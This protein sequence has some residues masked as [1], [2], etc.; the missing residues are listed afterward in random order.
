MLEQADKDKKKERVRSVATAKDFKYEESIR[1]AKYS[2]DAHLSG[3]QGD[4]TAATIDLYL[5]PSGDEL[6]RA[7]ASD[8]LT[9][10]EQNRKT[11]G[12]HMTYT[13]AD[14]RY[15]VTGAPVSIVDQC[16][17]ET[18]GKTLTFVKAT[19]TID[20][21]GNQRIRTQTK[22]GGKCP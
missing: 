3:P 14:E 16:G 17:R 12:S 8:S 18:I 15:V 4:M 7:E 2:G 22:G 1:R 10:H 13:A 20:V 11:V 21:D 6:D 19:D 5:T 9:L